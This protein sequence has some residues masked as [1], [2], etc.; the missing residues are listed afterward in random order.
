MATILDGHRIILFGDSITQFS[1]EECGWGAQIQNVYQRRADVVCRGYSGYNTRWA[2][3]LLPNFS[4]SPGIVTSVVT[5][6]FGANDASLLA[7][8]PQQHV[9]L[10]EY[11][12]NLKIIVD[13]LRAKFPSAEVILVTPP[14]IDDEAVLAGRIGATRNNTSAGKYAAAVAAVG[15]EMSAPV[16]NL[17]T[18]M[19]AAAP[20][21]THS[22]QEEASS[23]GNSASTAEVTDWRG[24]LSDGLHLTAAGQRFVGTQIVACINAARPDLAVR[25]NPLGGSFGNS[26]SESALIADGP[27]YDQVTDPLNFADLLTSHPLHKRC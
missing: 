21:V 8:N 24:F 16:V 25:C 1:F 27:W 14:P 10:D 18:S 19:Q 17:W 4:E 23:A 26:G 9:P 22:T 12:H 13:S 11:S 2:L 15:A 6:F 7:I 3:Q 5:V 20:L